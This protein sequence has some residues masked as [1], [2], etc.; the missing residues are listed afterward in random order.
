M[1]RGI[2]TPLA[3][4]A[5]TTYPKRKRERSNAP[6]GAG[7][8]IHRGVATGDSE[9]GQ[10]QWEASHPVEVRCGNRRR[11]AASTT[12]AVGPPREANMPA[13]AVRPDRTA[14]RSEPKAVVT[15]IG[16]E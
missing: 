16:A 13:A 8:R 4:T 10:D 14:G 2:R 5:S 6:S 11:Q 1:T 7:G 15:A 3:P 9:A 12:Q